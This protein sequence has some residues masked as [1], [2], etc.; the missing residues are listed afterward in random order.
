[1]LYIDETYRTLIEDMNEGAVT[2][3]ADGTILYANKAFSEMMQRA[4]EG[5]VGA[6][7][8]QYVA[9]A[10]R[11][12]FKALFQQGFQERGEGEIALNA[13]EGPDVPVYASANAVTLQG[14]QVL[15]IALTDLTEQKRQ[16]A[17]LQSERLSRAILQTA[18]EAIVV[19]DMDG[20]IIR[21]NNAARKF[22]ETPVLLKPFDE[23]FH[24]Q[25]APQD[26]HKPPSP[27]SV[28][29]V[30]QGDPLCGEEI[31]LR[32]A[33]KE[34][35]FFL[36]SATHLE[37][38]ESMIG[39]VLILTDTTELKKLER[40]L[41]AERE[42][43]SVTLL[44]I[45]DAVIVTDVEG[46]VV[47]MNRVGESLTGWSQEAALGQPLPEVFHIINEQTR[48]PCEN[49]VEKALKSGA[50]VGLANDTVLV[51]RDGTEKIIADSGSPIF[52]GGGDVVG[53]VLVFRDI[54]EHKRAEMVLQ[55]NQRRLSTLMRNLPGMAYRCLNKPGWPMDF[56]SEGCLALTGYS[57][58]ELTTNLLYGDLI[59]PQDRQ[60]VRDIIRESVHKGEPFVMEYRL[61]NREGRERWVWE[62]GQAVGENSDG[63]TILEGFV[64]DITDRK[65]A[66]QEV[67]SLGRF[68]EEN[69]SPI[70]R[71]EQDGTVLYANKAGERLL[72]AFDSGIGQGAPPKWCR[73]VGEA[74]ATGAHLEY[75]V[76]YETQTFSFDLAPVKE[77]G[78]VNWY[79]TDISERKE[80]ERA[81]EE[82]ERLLNEVGSIARIGGWEM[83]LERGGKATW[84]K[85]IYDIVE[86]EPGEPIPGFDDHVEWYLP[87]YREMIRKKMEDLI[88]TRVPAQFEAVLRTKRGNLK[89]CQAFGEA[90]ER[91]GKVV[92]LRGTFQ[93][94]T[95]RRR[96]ENQLRQAQKMESIG[97]LAGGIAH[98]FNNILAAVM[99]YTEMALG[100]APRGSTLKANL[101]EVFRGGK[102]AADL[103]RQ[104][105][106]FSRLSDQERKPLQVAPLVKEALKL[107]RSSLPASI[108]LRSHMETDLHHVLADPTQ[109]H[110]IT[111]NLCTNAAHAMRKDGGILDVHLT[112]VEIDAGSIGHYRD[113][114][115]GTYLKLT[116]SD[117][118]HGMS[119]QTLERA[120]EPYFTTK[121]KGR[122]TGMGL[123]VVH[124]IVKAYGGTIEADSEPG[125]GATF[126]VYLPAEKGQAREGEQEKAATP[127]PTGKER[128]LFVDDEPTLVDLGKL[129][130]ERLG[131]KVTSRTSSAEALEVFKA[132]PEAFDLVI[133]DMTMPEMSGDRLAQEI[134]T[135]RHDMPV[136]LCTGYSDQISRELAEEMGIKAFVMKPMVMQDLAETARRILDDQMAKEPSSPGP[137]RKA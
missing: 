7:M 78:Y 126:D 18:G 96:L 79:G 38:Q 97:T 99:G 37:S 10:D 1:M 67:R 134:M 114:T 27:F 91:G 95:E 124:G 76:A 19:C 44:S 31:I 30:L 110:Q 52:S 33:N 137:A 115:P 2:T 63:T 74:M 132:K 88:E 42:Q 43:L 5:I 85:G 58:I 4:P 46:K 21:A 108:E 104:I 119:P 14:E 71:I 28:S 41:A 32:Q 73:W 87:E 54:T 135:V 125:K 16:A 9:S 84:T 59:H 3:S 86:I 64:S 34:E 136:I 26:H 61:R 15:C 127:L 90:V 77:G 80:A 118:G 100:D 48:E 24:L 130:L 66:E 122:G 133:T 11:D 121:E 101:E 8:D 107:L 45:G 123:S 56:V 20:R 12:T 103:V 22:A 82:R 113:I 75:E 72:K 50:I 109:I 116:V 62:R 68:P 105:L 55:E 106:A 112:Q 131:Y 51:S 23:V 39:C 102:R 60:G 89:W 40:E 128:I 17:V 81:L 70:L 65:E 83:E 117:T 29:Q 129:R 35:R 13:A 57:A 49:P 36:L 53:V 6:S 92:K 69:P 47:L 120:F 94:M 93:D 25:R 111:M 98:D